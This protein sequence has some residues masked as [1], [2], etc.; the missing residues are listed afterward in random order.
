MIKNTCN[1]QSQVLKHVL[2]GVQ[3]TIPESIHPNCCPGT[4]LE[5]VC[6]A[7]PGSPVGVP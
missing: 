3:Y 7:Y 5:E 6:E 2:Q 4:V 1:F